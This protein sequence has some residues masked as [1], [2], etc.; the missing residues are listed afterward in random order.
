MFLRYPHWS[1]APTPRLK[2]PG[3]KAPR[4]FTL[5]SSAGLVPV[6]GTTLRSGYCLFLANNN[7]LLVSV[8]YD[9]FCCI[10]DMRALTWLQ[11]YYDYSN[12]FVVYRW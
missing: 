12:P 8:W 9:V 5:P 1:I 4:S 2:P 3:T 11:Q 6:H 10:A 7:K